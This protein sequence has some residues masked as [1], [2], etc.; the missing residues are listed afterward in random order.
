MQ[1][2]VRE[3]GA[4][5]DGL[6]LD[7]AAINCAIDKL[8]ENGGGE[9]LF[10]RGTYLTGTIFLASHLSLRF[11]YGAC[12]LGSPKPAD[13]YCDDTVNPESLRHYLF[14]GDNCEDLFFSGSGLIDGNGEAFLENDFLFPVKKASG[15]LDYNV[16]K[17]KPDRPV[18]LYLTRCRDVCIEGLRW[19]NAPAYTIWMIQCEH[20]R[21]CGISA[22]NPRTFPNSDV[23]DIDC[24]RQVRIRDCDFE[25]GDDCIALKS[26]PYRLGGEGGCH[27]IMVTDSILSS[28]TCAVRVGYEGDAPITDCS[29]SNLVVRD[30]RHGIDL[31]SIVP[32]VR[33]CRIEHGTPIERLQFSNITMRNVQQAFFLWAGRETTDGL[34]DGFIRN[35]LFS[36]ITAAC[37]GSSWIGA[38]FPGGIRDLTLERIQLVLDSSVPFR[39]NETGRIPSHWGGA[40]AIGCIN[41]LNIDGLQ[42]RNSQFLLDDGTV[43]F[44]SWKNVTRFYHDGRKLPESGSSS[45]K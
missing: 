14:Y 23:L 10:P 32:E 42:L 44:S 38:K 30:S 20:V 37:V 3:C 6:T 18:L 13:Y 4:V 8:R 31:L 34:H 7:T 19:Q 26:D 11:E 29:F 28:A 33:F 39:K 15:I 12:I 41:F 27:D 43:G 17:P 16:R 45:R 2:N 40:T 5:G 24:C 25:A 9:L 35:V 21:I 36:N 22:R 1:I